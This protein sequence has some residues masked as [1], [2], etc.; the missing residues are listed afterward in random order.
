MKKKVWVGALLVSGL[1]VPACVEGQFISFRGTQGDT[2]TIGASGTG[3][4]VVA[5]ER[6]IVF[7]QIDT[8]EGASGAA[9]LA[10]GALRSRVLEDLAALGF[11]ATLWGY[12]AGEAVNR[13]RMPPGQPGNEPRFEAKSGV[14]VVVEPASRL[15]EVISTALKAGA[16]SV[17][18]VEFEGSES[19]EAQRDAAELAVARARTAAESIAEAAGGRLGDLVNMTVVP[20][21]N[22]FVPSN[23]FF[24]GGF[25]GQGVL[26]YP[27]DVSVKVQVQAWW[28]FERR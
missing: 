3:E 14:R 8:E 24:Q 13:N 2:A 11:D 1:M 17:P 10:N 4:V 28:V 6:A 7:L 25:Q 26:L 22:T 15:D 20:D 16:S 12:G 5:P 19:A 27:S 18:F 23:R 21:Y 9:A